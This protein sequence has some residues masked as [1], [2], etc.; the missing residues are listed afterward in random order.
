VTGREL[1]TNFAVVERL[2]AISGALPDD[3]AQ[4]V[5]IL[6]LARDLQRACELPEPRSPLWI[7]LVERSALLRRRGDALAEMEIADPITW[8]ALNDEHTF[9]RDAARALAGKEPA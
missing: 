7:L 4:K 5:A 3:S 1:V 9:V 6:G 8:Q 2:L